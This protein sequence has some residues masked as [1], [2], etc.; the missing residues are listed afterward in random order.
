MN[1]PANRNLLIFI[2]CQCVA[3][4]GTVLVVTIGGI[5]G[6]ALAPD[7][8]LATVPMSIMVVGTA[9]TTVPAALLMRRVGRRL[10]FALAA[11]GGAAAALLGALALIAQ[12]FLLFCLC[13]ILIGAKVAFSQQYRFAAAES[14]IP[15]RAGSA[16]SM[17]LLGAVGGALL[18]PALATRA[19]SWVAAT[20][21]LGSF[22]VLAGLF[23]AAAA[24]LLLIREPEM[25]ADASVDQE[26]APLTAMVTRPTFVVA[27][28]AG[29]VGQGVM[30][31]VMTATPISMHVVDGFS[32]SETAGVVR[33]HVLAMYLPSLVSAV[34][35]A[36]LGIPRMMALGVAVLGATLAT[37]LQG[38]EYLHYW[39]ALALLGV[40]WNFLFVGGTSLL[41]QSYRPA[42]RFAAQAVNDFSVFGVAAL[43]SLLAGSVVHVAGWESVLWA[44]LPP[45]VLMA[46][47]LAWLSSASRRSVPAPR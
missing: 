4:A 32:L 9:L 42:E 3:T 20:P 23:T 6:V 31:F 40:G 1:I 24:A 5:V 38:H 16:V 7:P 21:F 26:R 10:G 19:S 30:T 25:P 28:L 35:I 22:L 29:V 2:L 37:A 14:V 41:V 27:V 33:A 11:A 44:S 45:L 8:A 39:V 13:T 15:A 18:G 43:G 46:G 36:R 47:A 12:S 17:V 34:L